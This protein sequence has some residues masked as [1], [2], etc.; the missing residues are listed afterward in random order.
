MSPP[1]SLLDLTL[2]TAVVH[3]HR[4]SDLSSVPDYLVYELFQ[5]TLA[6][7][8]LNDH[9]LRMF[10]GTGNDEVFQLVEALKIRPVIKPILPTRESIYIFLEQGCSDREF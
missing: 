7:G 6:A 8:K 2:V 3:I 10:L 4:F 9:V 1:P 5:K